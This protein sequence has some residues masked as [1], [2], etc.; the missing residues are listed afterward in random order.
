MLPWTAPSWYYFWSISSWKPVRLNS[1]ANS[2]ANSSSNHN[3]QA[4]WGG[5]K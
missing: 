2:V 1:V 3:E 4:L 5:G